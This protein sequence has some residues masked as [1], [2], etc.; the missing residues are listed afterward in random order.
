MKLTKDILYIS[1]IGL[2]IAFSSYFHFSQTYLPAK[3]REVSVYYNK[4]IEANTKIINVIQN[5]HK[6]VY[7]AVYTFTR[8][9][10]KD[11]LLAAQYR[12][13]DVQGI[14]DRDQ[15]IKIDAQKKIVKELREA[16]I[17][18]FVQDHDAIMHLKTVVT[19]HAYVSGS[20]NWTASATDRND[21]ILE[22]GYEEQLRRQHE[23]VIQKLFRRYQH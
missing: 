18:V 19:E 1:L 3:Q 22:I 15:S 20:Y 13:L 14:V 7:F 17:E 6:Y 23:V 21:E 16:G 10:L 11:A 2:I 8:N 12:G 9:D 5:A 4:D